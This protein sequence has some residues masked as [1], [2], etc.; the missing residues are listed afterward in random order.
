MSIHARI[1]LDHNATTPLLGAARDAMAAALDIAGNPSS[2]HREGRRAR[3]VVETARDQVAALLGAGRDEV[4]FTSGGSEANRLGIAGLAAG[5]RVGCA[6]IEHPSVLGAAGAGPSGSPSMATAGS[7]PTPRS[8]PPATARRSWRS[9][10][11][12]TSSG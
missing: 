6:P 9:R 3:H 5:G 1:Y 11:S 12:T 2:V 7:T 8:G 10:R 4:V